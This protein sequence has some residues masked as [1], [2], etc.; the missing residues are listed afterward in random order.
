[1]RIG[2]G[3]R[4][5]AREKALALWLNSTLGLVGLLSRRLE[6]QGAWVCFKKPVLAS[7]PVVDLDRLSDPRLKSLSQAYDAL[8]EK[9]L[10]PFPQMHEDPVRAAIDQA[11]RKVLRLPDLSILRT[12]LAQEPV[13]C[14]KR[15]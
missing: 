4:K 15:L 2:R 11:V 3:A 14:L 9:P 12:L 1:V 8:A 5:I 10:G 6:T 7:M 13:I